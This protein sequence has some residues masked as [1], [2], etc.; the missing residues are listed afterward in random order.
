MN[1]R[2]VGKTT[3]YNFRDSNFYLRGVLVEDSFVS[4]KLKDAIHEGEGTKFWKCKGGKIIDLG[5]EKIFQGGGCR[6]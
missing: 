5:L 6:R 2:R 1:L 4:D 3:R